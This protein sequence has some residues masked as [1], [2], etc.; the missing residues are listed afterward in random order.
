MINIHSL[1]APDRSMQMKRR[2]LLKTIGACSAFSSIGLLAACGGGGDDGGT[3]GANVADLSAANSFSAFTAAV[4][5]SSAPG[6]SSWDNDFSAVA[7]L[8]VDIARGTAPLQSG[9]YLN[10]QSSLYP[11]TANGKF[12]LKKDPTI[13]RKSRFTGIDLT[14]GATG[15]GVAQAFYGVRA[16]QPLGNGF[17]RADVIFLIEAIV[18]LNGVQRYRSLHVYQGFLYNYPAINSVVLPAGKYVYAG[19][20]TQYNIQTINSAEFVPPVGQIMT[21]PF[22]IEV[23]ALG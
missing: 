23:S 9:S 2:Q 14:N 12:T 17:I 20:L 10:Y 7:P 15:D 19:V 1:I 22:T 11:T 4:F 21:Y 6:F 8:G 13:A 3:T 5:G 18:S 16:V